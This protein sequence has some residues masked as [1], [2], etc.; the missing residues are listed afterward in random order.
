M[1]KKQCDSASL[2]SVRA[3]AHREDDR[4]AC[5]VLVYDGPDGDIFIAATYPEAEIGSVSRGVE[6]T[7]AK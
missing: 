2:P 6:G 3:I 4:F 1:L 5:S 7:H